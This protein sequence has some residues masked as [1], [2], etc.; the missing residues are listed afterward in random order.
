MIMDL[1][2]LN[3]AS[4]QV[5]SLAPM[6]FATDFPESLVSDLKYRESRSTTR[7][8]LVK[9]VGQDSVSK[10]NKQAINKVSESESRPENMD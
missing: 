8:G 5:G 1:F 6:D 4:K 10:S 2:C 3:F 7:L 9:L